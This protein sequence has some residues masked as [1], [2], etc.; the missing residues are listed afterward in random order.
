MEF[1]NLVQPYVRGDPHGQ[2]GD[3]AVDTLLLLLAP[4][5][6]HLAAEAWERRHG[7]HIHLKSWPVADPALVAEE[8]VTMVVQ[9]NGKLR[10][11]IEVSPSVSEEEAEALAMASPAVI[12]ALAGASPRRIIVKPPKL[13]NIV[14]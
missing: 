5:T 13:V 6:P 4:M 3:E 14:V 11:R 12:E 10:D 7:D 9:V 8:S 2:V 1:V